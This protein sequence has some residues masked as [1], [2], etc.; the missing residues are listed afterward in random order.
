LFAP[1]HTTQPESQPPEEAHHSMSGFRY[2]G[3][4]S[5]SGSS[6]AAELSEASEPVSENEADVRHMLSSPTHVALTQRPVMFP[7]HEGKVFFDQ[8]N[9]QLIIINNQEITR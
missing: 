4:S 6:S 3:S 9:R 1:E 8:T 2:R 5:E 7:P